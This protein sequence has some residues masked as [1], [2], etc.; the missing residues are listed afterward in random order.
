MG[1]TLVAPTDS[2]SGY[3][4]VRDVTQSIGEVNDGKLTI[5]KANLPGF[6]AS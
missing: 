2:P 6:P 1:G 4:G 5:V 3:P